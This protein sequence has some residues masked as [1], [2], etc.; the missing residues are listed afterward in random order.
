[1]TNA[2][3]KWHG[4]RYEWTAP[5]PPGTDGAS[6]CACGHRVVVDDGVPE[7][8]AKI[9][10]G[11]TRVGLTT[12]EDLERVTKPFRSIDYFPACPIDVAR[13]REIAEQTAA[14]SKSR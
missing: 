9:V 14:D 1:M 6:A 10:D 12:S 7:G 13:L 3:R 8:E 5:V 11:V 2:D 4:H